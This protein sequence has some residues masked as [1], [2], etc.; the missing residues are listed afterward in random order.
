M[1]HVALATP[2][3]LC[4]PCV[5]SNKHNTFVTRYAQDTG[6]NCYNFVTQT[7]WMAGYPNQALARSHEMVALSQELS[8]PYSLAVTLFWA[9]RLHVLRRESDKTLEQIEAVTALARGVI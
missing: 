6:I 9:A 7:L 5:K 3:T 4:A 8:H 2:Y 1:G